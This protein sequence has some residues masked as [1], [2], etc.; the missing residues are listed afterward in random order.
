MSGP[1]RVLVSGWVGAMNIG[2]ELVFRSLATKLRDRGVTVQVMSRDPEGTE[3]LH[4]VEAISWYNPSTVL[5]A[6]AGCDGFILGPGGLLQDE[7]SVWN[8]PAHLHRVFAAK[9][10][11]KPVLG[12]GLGAG[13]LKSKASRSLVRAALKSVPVTVRDEE[14]AAVLADCG[15]SNVTTTADPAFGLPIPTAEVA[16]RI[17]VSLRPFS[18]GG[19]VIPARRSDL[20]SFDS[21]DRIGAAARALDDLSVRTSLPIHLLAFEG[22]RDA[23]YHHR[24]ASEMS[25]PVTES[26]ASV[27]TVFD[28][29]A[30]SRLVVAMRY[31][32]VVSAVMAG[33]P[34][35]VIAYSPKVRSIGTLMGSG[36][37]IL[38]NDASS[39]TTIPDGADLLGTTHDLIA[40][41]DH[42]RHA[43][44]GNDQAID[45]LLNS[46]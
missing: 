43:E 6:I 19:G 13:P 18:G 26:T 11:R 45:N 38:E 32:A 40:V 37:L 23:P 39:L 8:L 2:D 7:T 41:R 15:I 35:V 16:D 46:I 12:L 44:S 42:L 10:A 3:A 34:A 9:T 24:I 21:D 27:D 25:A 30:K 20:R 4:E 33:R 22:E 5:G 17:V 31:H 36:A 29:I 1:T 28:E 14:S